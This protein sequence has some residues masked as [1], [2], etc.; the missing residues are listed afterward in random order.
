MLVKTT[1]VPVNGEEEPLEEAEQGD[2]VGPLGGSAGSLPTVAQKH[3]STVLE[4][5]GDTPVGVPPPDPAGMV[6]AVG[7]AVGGS[8]GG[9]E[10]RPACVVRDYAHGRLV[11]EFYLTGGCVWGWCGWVQCV[12]CLW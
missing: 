5:A 6:G 8:A 1:N 10:V 7:G 4:T 2:A 11:H 9:G 12:A 3:S